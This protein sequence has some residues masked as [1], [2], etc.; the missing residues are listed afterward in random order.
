[1]ACL[2][3][4][5]PL[6]DIAYFPIQMKVID[7]VSAIERRSK[8]AYIFH[9]EFGFFIGRLGGCGLFL[10]LAHVWGGEF[11]LRYAIL[12]VALV[13]LLSIPVAQYV[14]RG[15]DAHRPSADERELPI[16]PDPVSPVAVTT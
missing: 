5:R 16:S 7:T 15:C 1:M 2:L 11:A 3:M 14:L 8:F 6:H 12:F 9:Q 13:Q 10:L 4:A